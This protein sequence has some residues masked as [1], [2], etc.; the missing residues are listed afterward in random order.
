MAEVV[1]SESVN[2][3]LG[4]LKGISDL[5]PGTKVSALID[6][7]LK[8]AA[9]G[10][11]AGVITGAAVTT[12][13]VAIG[14]D[15]ATAATVAVSAG[16][17]VASGAGAGTALGSTLGPIGAVVGVIV[18]IFAGLLSTVDVSHY[19]DPAYGTATQ[20]WAKAY[21]ASH[22]VNPLL[23][24]QLAHDPG[25]GLA[26]QN[27][28]GFFQFD[29]FELGM[30]EAFEFKNGKA[31]RLRTDTPVGKAMHGFLEDLRLK[32]VDAKTIREIARL[33]ADFVTRVRLAEVEFQKDFHGD[34]ANLKDQA[35]WSWI[36]ADG[37]ASIAFMGL[38]QAKLASNDARATSPSFYSVDTR[39]LSTSGTD[40]GFT[41]E[42]ASEDPSVWPP[43][44]SYPYFKAIVAALSPGLEF[45]LPIT[46]IKKE[47]VMNDAIDLVKEKAQ[48]AVEVVY[49]DGE[50]TKVGKGLGIVAG[51][52]VVLKVLAGR[53]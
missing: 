50:V 37:Y 11:A 51:I 12:L 30:A 23:S 36:E 24:V 41:Q 20:S 53:R 7:V 49:K 47:S 28:L 16:A 15:V 48:E 32:G 9:V 31:V 8:D 17:A 44:D 22:P 45:N 5:S 27:S 25:F 19:G 29:L 46:L 4:T 38:P 13:A 39:K 2:V 10:T 43:V 52:L 40:R 26:I 18:G 33:Y 1:T 42:L 21:F 6:D 14:A 34:L 35:N 3:D